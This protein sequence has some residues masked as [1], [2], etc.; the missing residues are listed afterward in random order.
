MDFAI[1]IQLAQAPR[2]QLRHLGSEIDDQKFVMLGH[3]LR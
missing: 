1:D 2:D 3:G